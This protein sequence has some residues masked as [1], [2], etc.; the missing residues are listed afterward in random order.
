MLRYHIPLIYEFLKGR[1]NVL[2]VN[3]LKAPPENT[4]NCLSKTVLIRFNAV[5]K[6][7]MLTDSCSLSEGRSWEDIYSVL[8]PEL[9]G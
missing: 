5:R 7:T 6:N 2:A 4:P 1:N 3:S 8:G 9:A